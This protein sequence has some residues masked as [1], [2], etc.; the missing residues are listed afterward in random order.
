M[1]GGGEA[2]CEV[3]GVSGEKGTPLSDHRQAPES[4]PERGSEL[5]PMWRNALIYPMPSPVPTDLAQSVSPPLCSCPSAT[6]MGR[7][8]DGDG[9]SG[10]K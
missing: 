8:W 7:G 5:W 2:A 9:T 10:N 4:A 1:E 6:G 3:E